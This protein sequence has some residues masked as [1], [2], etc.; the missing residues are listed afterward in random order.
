MRIRSA[1][2]AT[3]LIAASLVAFKQPASAAD[4][5]SVPKTTFP[6]CSTTRVNY[7]IDTVTIQSP[8]GTAENLTF[9]A[10]GTA[11]AV[12]GGAATP[13]PAASG[14]A[15]PAPSASASASAPAAPADPGAD[16][17]DAGAVVTGIWTNSDWVTNGHSALGYSGLVIDAK[18]VNAFDNHLYLQV[19]PGKV[20]ASNKT[21]L[22][23]QKGSTIGAPAQQS[24][25][26]I[27][28]VKIRVQNFQAGVSMGFGNN[29]AVNREGDGTNNTLTITG[30]ATPV[31]MAKNVKD[32]EGE[33]GIAAYTSNSLGAL[34]LAVNDPTAGFGVDGVSGDMTV[35]SNG[36]CNL[37]T[38]V[39][40][41]A[42]KTLNWTAAAPHFAADGKTI[43]Q[44]FYKALIPVAD[45]KLLWGLTNPN[46]AASALQVSMTTDVNNTEVNAVKS[47][48]VKNGFIIISSTGYQYS[49]PTFKIKKNPSYKPSS[50][51]GTAKKTIT[52]VKGKVVKSV[53]ATAACPKGYTKK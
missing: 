38:P 32:C 22:A 39:W 1:L 6:V 18:A 31:A 30:S 29:V 17:T 13:A 43:N 12:A 42:N 26:D 50:G 4:A 8:G 28:S 16:L 37:S 15:T 5:L 40:D 33:A 47:I 36:I 27:V 48:A 25:D 2:F 51:S 10:N 7:C 14:A 11:L 3:V 46:D 34:V 21:T 24:L 35:S 53:P 19:K 45:A 9:Q 23:I 52:C 49:K 41:E 20:D 44:G